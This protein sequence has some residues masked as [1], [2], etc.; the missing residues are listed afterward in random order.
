MSRS[1]L[2]VF[3]VSASPRFVNSV[4]HAIESLYNSTREQKM[5]KVARDL[6]LPSLLG[7]NLKSVMLLLA[8]LVNYAFNNVYS[9]TTLQQHYHCYNAQTTLYTG[10]FTLGWIPSNINKSYTILTFTVGL[11]FRV[12][13]QAR[14]LLNSSSHVTSYHH[15]MRASLGD[16]KKTD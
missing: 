3:I 5:C 1:C 6:H 8:L 13:S 14:N 10:L 12:D 11:C 9:S 7:T 15:S 2:L 16:G 4:R